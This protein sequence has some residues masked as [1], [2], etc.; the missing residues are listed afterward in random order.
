[1]FIYCRNN[2]VVHADVTGEIPWLVI[3]V[4]VGCAVIGGVLG[5]TS[6]KNLAEGV[7]A[8]DQ[9]QAVPDK[10][11]MMTPRELTQMPQSDFNAMINDHPNVHTSSELTA[12][13]RVVN[14]L[15]G[16][17]MGLAVGGALVSVVGVVGSAVVGS[18]TT[19]IT[20]LGGTGL[21]TFA[22]GALIY[23]FF[24]TIVAPFPGIEMEPI[25]YGP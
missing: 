9:V 15:I 2:P 18:A 11:N 14:G 6:D 16:A 23:N 5:A 21:Q 3:G 13:D 17:G 22:R 12:G 20:A 25:E 1:M 19:T 7:L 4:L 10:S 8:L 24:A